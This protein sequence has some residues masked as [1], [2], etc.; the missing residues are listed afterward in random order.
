MGSKVIFKESGGSARFCVQTQDCREQRKR[1]HSGA[2]YNLSQDESYSSPAGQFPLLL[3]S[4]A[5]FALCCCSCQKQTQTCLGRMSVLSRT[6]AHGQ[7]RGHDSAS[8]RTAIHRSSVFVPIIGEARQ[9][10]CPTAFFFL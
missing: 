6:E 3:L 1:R 8:P 10:S 2:S 9:L 7:V 4:A 5:L